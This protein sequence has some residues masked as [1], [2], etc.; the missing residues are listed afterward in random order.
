MKPLPVVLLLGVGL[1]GIAGVS[2]L[3]QN[4]CA[5]RLRGRTVENTDG[6]ELGTVRDFIVNLSAGEVCYV[7]IASGGFL[8]LGE[9]QMVVPAQAVSTATAKKDVVALDVNIP[10]WQRAPR[11]NGHLADVANPAKSQRIL[12]FYA[13]LLPATGPARETGSGQSTGPAPSPTGRHVETVPDPNRSY[14]ALVSELVGR[15]M[16]N[17]QQEKLGTISDLLLDLSGRKPVFAILATG[18]ILGRRGN[19]AVPLRAVR[20]TATRGLELDA[21][22]RRFAEAPPFN[23]HAWQAAAKRADN[24]VYRYVETK[25]APLAGPQS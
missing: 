15:S 23:E 9:E 21:N 18:S 17:R 13:P 2:S 7:I 20:L 4:D 16:C 14:I 1:L 25:K 19:F 10:R 6:Q 24:Q 5:S 22:Q 3:F 11:F 12:Q 8:G